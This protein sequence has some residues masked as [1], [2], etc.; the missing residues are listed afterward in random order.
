VD[1]YEDFRPFIPCVRDALSKHGGAAALSQLDY[2]VGYDSRLVDVVDRVTQSGWHLYKPNVRLA[3]A[4]LIHAGEV[5]VDPLTMFE[6][7]GPETEGGRELK[8]STAPN[9]Y[10][11]WHQF[12]TRAI[13]EFGSWANKRVDLGVP[14]I[15]D[16]LM[17]RGDLFPLVRKKMSEATPQRL[18]QLVVSSRFCSEKARFEVARDKSLVLITAS[19][20]DE[21]GT[22]VKLLCIYETDP[23]RIIDDALVKFARDRAVESSYRDVQ[24][25]SNSLSATTRALLRASCAEPQML[26][27]G[28]G[29]IVANTFL[30][31]SGRNPILYPDL[32]VS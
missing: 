15:D 4:A 12:M 6:L 8:V 5:R 16:E 23:E 10:A 25:M 28:C 3:L 24:I 7:L 17:D 1:Y 13:S 29:E 9:A 26:V 21:Y 18:V 11:S 14:K 32:G 27:F 19:Q 2:D 30:A 22:P 20:A 31:D